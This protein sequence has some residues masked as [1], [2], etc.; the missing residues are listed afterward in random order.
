MSKA[1]VDKEL[2]KECLADLGEALEQFGTYQFSDKGPSEVMNIDALVKKFRKLDPATAGVTI[3]KLAKSKKYQGRPE[4]VASEILCGMQDWDELW[5]AVP[6]VSE[7][8]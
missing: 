3:C 7:Y 1:K 5:D 4:Y 6:E 2:V 8:L